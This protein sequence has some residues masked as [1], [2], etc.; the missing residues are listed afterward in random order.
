MAKQPID[1]WFSIGSMYAYLSVMRLPEL[2]KRTG[3]ASAGG[4]FRCA[5][6]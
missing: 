4:R 2:A 1:F 5:T 6:S 3:T